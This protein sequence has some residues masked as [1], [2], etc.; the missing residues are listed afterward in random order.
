MVSFKTGD[1]S[2]TFKFMSDFS[3]MVKSSN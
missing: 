2:T 3:Y 1:N